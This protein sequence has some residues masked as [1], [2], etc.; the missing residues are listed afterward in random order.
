MPAAPAGSATVAPYVVSDDAEG[1]IEFIVDVFGATEVQAARVEGSDGLILHA[2]LL[3][4]DSMITVIERKPNWPYTPA[5]MRVYVD[6]VEQACRRASAQGGIVLTEPTDYWG[7]V[8][9]RIK[10]PFGHLWWVFQHHPPT[11]WGDDDAAELWINDADLAW[12]S[13]ATPELTYIH[14]SLIEAM[15]HLRDPRLDPDA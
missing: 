2:E 7:D 5:F 4:G 13:F 15:D 12:G 8:F 14:A 9:A 11:T 10:D 3:L 1:L 6:D